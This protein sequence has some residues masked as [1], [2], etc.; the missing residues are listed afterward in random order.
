MVEEVEDDQKQDLISIIDYQ[1]EIFV[2]VV[3][4]YELAVYGV[5]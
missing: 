4:L 5:S 2:S 3:C 1:H